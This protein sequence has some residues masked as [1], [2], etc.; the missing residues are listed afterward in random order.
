[1]SDFCIKGPVMS[2]RIKRLPEYLFARIN[3][4]KAS[5]RARGVDVID[6]GMGNPDRPPPD[7][8]VEKLCEAARDSK[9]HRYSASRGI[10]H[11]RRGIAKRYMDMY[12]VPLDPETETVVTIGSKEGLTHLMFAML[13]EGDTVIVPSPTYPIHTFGVLLAGGKVATVPLGNPADLVPRLDR[14]IEGVTPKPKVLLL[15]FPHNPTATTVDPGFFDAVVSLARKHGLIVI[16][17]LAYAD[18]VFDG[19]RAPSFLQSPGAKE[20]GVE[21]FSMT[22]SYNMAGWR[23]GF[24][25][26][27]AGIVAALTKLKSYL[28]YGIF[29]PIQVASISALNAGAAPCA[30]IAEVYRSRMEVLLDGLLKLGFSVDRPRATMYL[31][32]RLPDRYLAMGSMKFTETLLEDAAVAVAPGTGFGPEGEGYLRFALVENE[33]RTKQAI[34]NMRRMFQSPGAKGPDPSIT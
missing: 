16:H 33:E 26:G 10:P 9:A 27:N 4:L 24:M 3:M 13:N 32:A 25:V 15:S 31:W 1:M 29:T 28:D 7:F 8:I 34:R 19:Y 11:L 18:L 17:D 30:E 5:A 21:F 14:A 23:V 22:K 6:F 2:D 12:G 20:V